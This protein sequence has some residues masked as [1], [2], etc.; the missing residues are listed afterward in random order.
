[1]NKKFKGSDPNLPENS[2]A[3]YHDQKGRWTDPM[4]IA[5]NSFKSENEDV[6][7]EIEDIR[8]TLKFIQSKKTI[9]YIFGTLLKNCERY[10]E[11]IE[12]IE[13][14][15]GEPVEDSDSSGKFA[16]ETKLKDTR[17]K[18]VHDL[19]I[20][21]LSAM[22]RYLYKNFGP[23]AE[24]EENRHAPDQLP[25]YTQLYTDAAGN[26]RFE[27]GDWAVRMAKAVAFLTDD[28]HKLLDSF[29]K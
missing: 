7:E 24:N 25:K 15:K 14:N 20:G 16:E 5:V 27:V 23:A 17:R 3:Y 19:I 4:E 28:E 18:R 6:R 11:C 22:K 29:I 9:Q 1:M 26:A 10:V 12:A 13:E 21:D 8:S 2:I